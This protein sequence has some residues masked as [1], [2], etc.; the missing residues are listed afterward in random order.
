MYNELR[1]QA[2]NI[3]IEYVYGYITADKAIEL[4]K[5]LWNDL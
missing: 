1:R 5:E 3:W 2:D 4:L